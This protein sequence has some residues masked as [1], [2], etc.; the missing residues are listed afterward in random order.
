LSNFPHAFSNNE[1]IFF[2]NEVNIIVSVGSE[3]LSCRWCL[4]R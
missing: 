2:L 1:P 3:L 4:L